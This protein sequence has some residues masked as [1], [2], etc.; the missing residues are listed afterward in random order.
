MSGRIPPDAFDFYVGLGA[1]R[2]YQLVADRFGVHKR[3]VTKCAVREE[4]KPK[5]PAVV[6]VDSTV[7]PQ[8]IDRP[9]NP[10]YYDILAAYK[11]RTGLPV[12]INTSFNVHEDPIINTPEECAEALAERRIDFVAT[13]RAVYAPRDRAGSAV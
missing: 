4:W 13:E 9:S 5:I 12:L 3:T 8:V 11:Q 10:T 2:S 6:H 1:N 7:R